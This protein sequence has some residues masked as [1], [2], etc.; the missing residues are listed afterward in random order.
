LLSARAA[1]LEQ[2]QADKIKADLSDS[3]G[4]NNIEERKKNTA[5]AQGWK[6]KKKFY[7]ENN[8]LLQTTNENVDQQKYKNMMPDQNRDISDKT[9]SNNL[10]CH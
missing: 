10:D 4:G 3:N 5:I 8:Q 7:R 6:R 9:K 2:N 1:S